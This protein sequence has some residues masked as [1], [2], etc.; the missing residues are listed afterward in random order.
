MHRCLNCGGIDLPMS[1]ENPYHPPE[2]K[3]TPSFRKL[4]GQNR[5]PYIY[6]TAVVLLFWT[7]VFAYVS[8]QYEV[9]EVDGDLMIQTEPRT[10]SDNSLDDAYPIVEPYHWVRLR[11]IWLAA[12]IG[13]SLLLAHLILWCARCISA[14]E[15]V[16]Q[17]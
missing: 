2:A 16:F 11:L 6:L 13:L 1:I 12:F 10:I 14:K 5:A 17:R 7:G 9:R 3:V 8:Q 4:R 15:S